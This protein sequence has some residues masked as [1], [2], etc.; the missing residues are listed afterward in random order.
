[1]IEIQRLQPKNAVAI[2]AFLV[3]IIPAIIC[4]RRTKKKGKRKFNNVRL[5]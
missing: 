2:A 5:L 3:G 1:M 4:E